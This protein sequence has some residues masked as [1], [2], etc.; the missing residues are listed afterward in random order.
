MII[1]LCGYPGSGKDEIAKHLV[2]KHGFVR[3]AFADAMRE[4]LLKLDPIVTVNDD[5]FS[6]SEIVNDIGWDRAK[7][8]YP[9]V[10]RLLQVYG[11]EV[12]REAFG[13]NC[14]VDRAY[15]KIDDALHGGS[16]VV[17]TD[18]RFK[19]EVRLIHQW[20]GSHIVHVTRPGFG[21]INNHA[22]EQLDY[23][24]VADATIINDST[25]ENLQL[26]TSI[27]LDS[28]CKLTNR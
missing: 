14:W 4:D 24:A 20:L 28:V 18:V 22:S 16:N 23:A 12:G 1:G 27:L 13:E 8:D 5:G 6:L 2:A 11:T 9:E 17:V 3:V 15:A 26:L 19:N 25:L 10:R 7:R 21:K